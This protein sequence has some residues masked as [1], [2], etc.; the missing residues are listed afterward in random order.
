MLG[1]MLDLPINSFSGTAARFV[2]PRVK[3]VVV[4]EQ[5]AMRGAGSGIT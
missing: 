2:H 4:V 5:V 1:V 3:L